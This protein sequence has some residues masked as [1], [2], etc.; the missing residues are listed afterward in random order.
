MFWQVGGGGGA[1]SDADKSPTLDTLPPAPPTRP[2]AATPMTKSIPLP[3]PR[4]EYS[5]VAFPSICNDKLQH[6]VFIIFVLQI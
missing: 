4:V 3:S 2:L 5:R 6:D 1:N